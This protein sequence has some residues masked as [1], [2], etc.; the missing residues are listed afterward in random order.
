[1]NR[2]VLAH[3]AS[4][5][6]EKTFV[7]MLVKAGHVVICY[8]MT[9]TLTRTSMALDGWTLRALKELAAKWDVS[10]AEVMRRAVKRAK[11]D[12]DREAALP[13]P[14]EALD[15][16]HDGGGLTVKEAAA[17]REQVRAERLA[18]KYWW[19]A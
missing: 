5:R 9:Y 7:K 13:K 12:A 10:K 6:A 11:E 2:T 17:H 4:W 8:H 1:M 3:I 18:K 16:L 14:L 19:E 15:W